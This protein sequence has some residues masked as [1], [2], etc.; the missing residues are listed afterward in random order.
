MVVAFRR[1]R[2]LPM[3]DCSDNLQ[4]T[5]RADQVAEE[6][7]KAFSMRI[8]RSYPDGRLEPIQTSP[9]CRSSRLGV[10]TLISLSSS[11]RRSWRPN[12]VN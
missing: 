6:K 4:Q 7:P 10:T 9:Y 2:L 8:L 12:E 5:T 3:D 1:H 11:P